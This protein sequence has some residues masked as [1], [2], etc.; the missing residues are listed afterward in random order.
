ML[1]KIITVLSTYKSKSNKYKIYISVLFIKRHNSEIGVW[2]G[3]S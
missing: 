2:A 1:I 3:D